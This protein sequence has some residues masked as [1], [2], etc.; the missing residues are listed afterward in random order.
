MAVNKPLFA[1]VLTALVGVFSCD[2]KP[3]NQ[4]HSVYVK[5]CQSCHLENGEGLGALIP[6]VANADYVTERSDELACLITHG[7]SGNITVN[8]VAYEGE[9]PGNKLLTDV[10]L[11]NLIHYILVDLNQQ[12]NPYVINDIKAQLANCDAK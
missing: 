2:Y 5:H 11:T 7:I 8:G 6:P 10:E 4:G 1:L 9:M 12:E 3:R